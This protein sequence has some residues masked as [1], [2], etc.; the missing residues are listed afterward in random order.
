M[1]ALIKI[2]KIIITKYSLSKH[3]QV[4]RKILV[5]NYIKIKIIIKL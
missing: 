4:K 2:I 1:I 3:I 5:F